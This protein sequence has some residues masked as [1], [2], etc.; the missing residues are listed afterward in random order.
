M[1]E[2]KLYKEPITIDEQVDWQFV[3]LQWALQNVVGKFAK[4]CGKFRMVYN[5]M[6]EVV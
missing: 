5:A 4:A 3:G 6:V 1:E 2:L